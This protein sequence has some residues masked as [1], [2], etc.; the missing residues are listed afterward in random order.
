MS[1]IIPETLFKNAFAMK[2]SESTCEKGNAAM[3][4]TEIGKITVLR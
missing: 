3:H 4:A 1:I 2:I